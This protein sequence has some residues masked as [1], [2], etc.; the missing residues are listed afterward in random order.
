[1][2]VHHF[3]VDLVRERD[4]VIGSLRPV[5]R[6]LVPIAHIELCRLL[7]LVEGHV[8]PHLV[9]IVGGSSRGLFLLSCLE[10]PQVALFERVD[11]LRW[12]EYRLL[13]CWVYG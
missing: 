1:L 2:F 10:S 6:R 8:V 3:G 5:V 12:S 9:S 11:L 4:I 13:F 7:L